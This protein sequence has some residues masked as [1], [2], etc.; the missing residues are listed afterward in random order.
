[1]GI[2]QYTNDGVFDPNAISVTVGSSPIEVAATIGMTPD[3]MH[4]NAATAQKK[5]REL[6]EVLNKVS[7][8]FGSGRIA[9]AWL[10][11]EPLSGFGGLTAMQL[12]KR[13]KIEELLDFI[14]SVDAGVHA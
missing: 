6:S 14:D 2:L 10:R 3:E 13:G 1:M 11:S 9:F 8:R 12:L 7:P 4:R 5:L